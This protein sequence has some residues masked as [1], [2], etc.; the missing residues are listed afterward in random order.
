MD[1][2]SLNS[3]VLKIFNKGCD[4][5]FSANV[6]P[7]VISK[8]FLYDLFQK[9]VQKFDW[10]GF[11]VEFSGDIC[12]NLPAQIYYAEY[13]GED[14]IQFDLD[15]LLF[16]LE[17][18]RDVIISNFEDVKEFVFKILKRIHRRVLQFVEI[19]LNGININKLPPV[20]KRLQ[21]QDAIQAETLDIP[22]SK[23]IDQVNS[24]LS[25]KTRFA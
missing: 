8:S 24:I 3:W 14:K 5:L 6:K 20:I 23:F 18:G 19:R 7:F 12:S 25:Q 16:E 9:N 15:K 2:V 17:K 10:K 22:I 1:S 4:C 21:Y 13:H 11:L